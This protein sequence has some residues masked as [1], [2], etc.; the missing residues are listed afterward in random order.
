MATAKAP[1]GQVAVLPGVDDR[2]T[3]IFS[4]LVKRTY[5]IVPGQ[6][7]VRAEADGPLIAADQYFDGGDPETTTVRQESDRAPYKPATDVVVIGQVHAPPGRSLTVTDAG[8]QVGTHRK[9]IRAFGDRQCRFRSGRDPVVTEPTPFQTLEL[10]Y[11]RAYGGVD[12]HSDPVMPFY[13]PR[14]ALG[15]GVAV[16]NVRE[17]VEGLRLPNFEDPQDLLTPE[18]IVL[19][20]RT[21]WNRQP[22]PQG[23][24]WFPK[25]AY[26]RCSFL[27]AMPGDVVLDEPL[28]EE[29]LG[30]VPQQQ[31]A[32]ARQFRLPRFDVRFQRG[33]S[34]G[35]AVPFLAGNEH[36]IL[37]HLTPDGRLEFDLPNDPPRIMLDI[38]LGENELPPVLHTV[39]IRPEEGQVDLVWRGAH[40]YPGTDWLPEMKCLRVVVF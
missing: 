10:R 16:N 4:V 1:Q 12:R 5:R 2:G 22:L 29:L 14:N 8:V 17:A 9:V 33:A 26:P 36:V 23:F 39:C 21:R 27:G 19:G 38:S 30:L 28:R 7:A 15:C 11:E 6:P 13:Y 3:P 18:R 20:Q 35:L 32:L 34:L 40:E 31:I 37:I 25:T 24:G